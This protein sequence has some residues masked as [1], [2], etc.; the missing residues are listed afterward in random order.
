MYVMDNEELADSPIQQSGA[1][2]RPATIVMHADSGM[3][4]EDAEPHTDQEG[5]LHLPPA[6]GDIYGPPEPER[7]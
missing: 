2:G 3:A 7:R 5:N 6:Y 4:F 1:S